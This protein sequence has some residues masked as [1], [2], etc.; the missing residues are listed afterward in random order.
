MT[1][2]TESQLKRFYDA[3]YEPEASEAASALYAEWRALSAR[4]KAAHVETLL[5]AGNL[6]PSRV[7][8]V[9]CGD[10]ALMAEL[11]RRGVGD[12]RVGIEVSESAVPLARNQ[13]GVTDARLFDGVTIPW[14]DGSFDL[15]VLSHVLEHVLDPAALLAEAR[16]VARAVVVE[17]PLEA[18]LSARRPHKRVHAA[19]IGH[20]HQLGR[21]DMRRI[22]GDAGL[23]VRAEAWDAL[24]LAVHRFFADTPPSRRR[25]TVKWAARR[26]ATAVSAPAA[27]RLFT[28][29]YAMLLERPTSTGT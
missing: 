2:P 9:G 13:P 25:A 11:H 24:G 21:A 18:N 27:A 6:R 3:C 16:R 1:V 8:D 14:A 19:E 7:L 4:T 12:E 15:A 5:A 29:H 22:A 28:L 10:G 26:C 23:V 20:L 17:V